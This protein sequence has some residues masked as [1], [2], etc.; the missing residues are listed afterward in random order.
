MNGQD[1]QTF[2]TFVKK[3]KYKLRLY[4]FVPHIDYY[5]YYFMKEIKINNKTS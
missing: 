1:T 4:F 5:Y 2:T 3:Q